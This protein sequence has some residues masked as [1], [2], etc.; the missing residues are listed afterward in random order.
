[1]NRVLTLFGCFLLLS[2]STYASEQ[3]RHFPSIDAPTTSVALCNL[4][5]YNKKLQAVV[6]KDTLTAEDMVKVHELTYTLENAVIKLQ[7][8]LDAIA[9]NLEKVHKASEV[10][11][12]AVINDSGKQYLAAIQLIVDAKPCQ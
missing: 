10:L 8:D 1:M 3:Y 6:N 7:K 11:D 5:S 4:A 12:R 9:I 2:S